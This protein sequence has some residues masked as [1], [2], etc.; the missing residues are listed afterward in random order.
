MAAAHKRPFAE[1][2]REFLYQRFLARVFDGES[3]WVL[4]GGIGLLT[5]LPGARHSRDID[6]VHLAAGPG[7]AE[8]EIRALGRM[9]LGDYLRFEVVRAVPLSVEDALRLKTDAYVGASR[10]ESF[11]VD[12]SCERHFVAS[13]EPIRPTPIIDVAGAP[14]LPLFRLYPLVDQIADKVAA[15]YETHG[16]E[17]S[18]RYRDLVDLVL[19]TGLE[20]LDAALLNAA[21]QARQRFSRSP[22][23]LPSKLTSPGTTWRAGFSREARRSSVP[24]ALQDLDAALS[25]VADCLDPALSGSVSSGKWD[26][27]KRIWLTP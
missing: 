11:D 15:M 19:L 18:N 13:I 24:I 27:T 21:L 5:R 1:V 3:A 23:A 20:K 6:L 17:P 4:K 2:R 8:A 16:G 10:W 22:L 25:Y 12:I 14:E 9:D 7:A 26:P